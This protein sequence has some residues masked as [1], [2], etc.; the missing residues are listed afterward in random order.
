MKT[1]LNLCKI[2]ANRL[3]LLWAVMM[4]SSCA[5]PGVTNLDKWIGPWKG[6][7]GTSLVINKYR[8]GYDIVIRD[9]DGP[10]RFQATQNGSG[11]SFIRDG[12]LE[13]LREGN[14]EETGMKWLMDK[15]HCLIVKPGEGYCQY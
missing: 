5:S 4:I 2:T 11:L 10:R 3:F 8:Q 1:R 15:Q 9:L 6:P 12:V 13:T 14:G 7:E